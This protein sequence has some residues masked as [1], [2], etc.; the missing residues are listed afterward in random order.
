MRVWIQQYLE[1]RPSI[2]LTVWAVATSF[3]TYFCMYAFRKPFAAGMYSGQ[4]AFGGMLELKTVFVISQIIGY[5]LSKYAGIKVCTEVKR[6]QRLGFLLG[7]IA[8]AEGALFLFAV[9]P[10]PWKIAA[11]FLNGLPLGMVWGFVVSYL[12]GRRSSEIQ[13][14][15]LSCSFIIAS[16]VVKDVGRWILGLGVSEYWMPFVTGLAFLPLFL[17]SAVLLDVLPEPNTADVAERVLR[18]PM[19]GQERWNFI[20]RFAV[21]LSMLLVVYFA[22]TAYRDFRDNYG[23]ELFKSLGYGQAPAVFTRTEFW[24]ALGVL[25]T[26]VP[27]SWI[28]DNRIALL[29]VYGLL[30]GG[31]ILVGVSN[32]MLEAGWISGLTWM[33]LVGVGGYLAYVPYGSVLFDRLVAATRTVGTAVFAI[34]VCDAVGYTGSTA[35]QLYKDLFQ[36]SAT[37]LDFFIQFGYVMSVFGVV[38]LI[39]SY[40]DFARAARKAEAPE[41]SFSEFACGQSAACAMQEAD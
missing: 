36:A 28:R 27:L 39:I 33:I 1:R 37:R 18:R 9:L 12:E 3:A 16:G 29:A 41:S 30:V 32:L 11:I 35:L 7:A 31:C 4:A 22:L 21:G 20:R 19:T 17:M 5:T 2:V 6:G 34:Y 10:G 26:L 25:A 8:V 38:L 40:L 15:G 14:A 24:V 23:V 13:L